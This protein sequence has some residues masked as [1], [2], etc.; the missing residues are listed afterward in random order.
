MK[1]L[2][3]SL[4]S[5]LGLFFGVILTFS[6]IAQTI[7]VQIGNQTG[8][9]SELPITSCWAFSYTQQIYTASE[10]NAQGVTSANISSLRFYYASGATTN[11][12]G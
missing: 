1:V 11:S 12:T 3:K 4:Q 5:A 10:L 9:A 6:T 8:T 7:D 2:Y